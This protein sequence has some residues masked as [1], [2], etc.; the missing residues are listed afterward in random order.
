VLRRHYF[1]FYREFL[2]SAGDKSIEC[3]EWSPLQ[4]TTIAEDV[5]KLP[6]TMTRS[7][8]YMHPQ[9]KNMFMA[10]TDCKVL[11]TQYCYVW[12]H[13]SSKIATGGSSPQSTGENGESAEKAEPAH[14]QLQHIRPKR[15]MILT[16]SQFEG[17]PFCDYFKVLAYYGFDDAEGSNRGEEGCNIRLGVAVHFCKSTM[18]KSQ[19]QSG[20]VSDFNEFGTTYFNFLKNRLQKAYPSSQ[21]SAREASPKEAEPAAPVATNDDADL[22]SKL[23]G[24]LPLRTIVKLLVGGY[25]VLLVLLIFIWRQNAALSQSVTQL[26]NDKSEFH[27][28]FQ[29]QFDMEKQLLQSQGH[30]EGQLKTQFD[31]LV[32]LLMASSAHGT[33]QLDG[34]IAE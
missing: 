24:L 23:F 17:I 30:M 15:A 3:G 8:T 34:H 29:I 2:K 5:S 21:P 7:A 33:V 20:V 12:G 9:K 28:N 4:N 6:F 13:S 16:V 31:M 14:L 1:L 11:Q 26:E 25:F 27:R 18:L 32:K 19:I 22:N 10:A